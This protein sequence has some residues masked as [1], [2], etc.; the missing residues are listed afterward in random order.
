M[1]VMLLLEVYSK[2]GIRPDQKI[3]LDYE[4]RIKCK[5]LLFDKIEMKQLYCEQEDMKSSDASQF[6]RKN[7]LYPNKIQI[8]MF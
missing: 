4:F 3:T 8:R 2:D 5:K 7:I 1:M 6:C